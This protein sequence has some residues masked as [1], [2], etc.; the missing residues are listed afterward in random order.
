MNFGMVIRV[1]GYL[2]LVLGFVMA[3]PIAVA[4]YYHEEAVLAFGVASLACITVGM[5]MTLVSDRGFKFQIKES[6]LMVAGGWMLFALFGAIPY[7]AGS[8]PW[9]DGTALSYT[10][11]V[12]ETMSGLTTTGA[13]VISDIE[14]LPKSTLFWRALTHW[15]GGM[16]IIVLSL[17]IMPLLG[18]RGTHCLKPKYPV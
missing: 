14:A 16:G 18:S 8:L 10:D 3:V 4:L 6:F 1:W 2:L 11:A 12:F 7:W 17:A 9:I 5:L 13:S 15:L